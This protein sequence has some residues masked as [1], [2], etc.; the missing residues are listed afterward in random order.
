MNYYTVS[1]LAKDGQ[2]TSLYHYTV[3][4]DGRTRPTG[5]CADGCPGHSTPDEAREHYRQY[6][7]DTARF[8]GQYR[9]QFHCEVCG[10]WTQ[11]FA[12]TEQT[13]Y[14]LCDEHRNRAALESLVGLPGDMMSSD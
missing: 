8:D 12:S 1:E 3:T 10:A 7:L 2:A 13:M 9:A 14:H 4:N 6:I 11:G 5:Y